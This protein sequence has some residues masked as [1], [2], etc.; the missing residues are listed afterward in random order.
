MTDCIF[1]KIIAKEIPTEMIYEDD[2]VIAFLDIKPS[3][4]GHTLVVPKKHSEDLLDADDETLSVAMARIKKIAPAVLSAVGASGFNLGVN[5]GS[6]S[7]QVI[8]HLHFHIIPRHDA[9]GL[10]AWPHFDA[11]PKRRAEI[12][13][14]IKSLLT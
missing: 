4:P 2:Q 5:T 9:D 11:E 1:C 12:A 8:F 3:A 7:G 6:S 10:K 13:E 14:K